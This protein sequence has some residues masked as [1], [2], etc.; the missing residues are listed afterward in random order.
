M[1]YKVSVVFKCKTLNYNV[2]AIAKVLLVQKLV[3]LVWWSPPNTF[4]V[5]CKLRAQECNTCSLLWLCTLI[6]TWK[7]HVSQIQG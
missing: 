7:P 6:K 2:A 3:I 1:I 4:T 5:L